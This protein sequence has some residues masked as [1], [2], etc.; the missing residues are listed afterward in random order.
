MPD[1]NANSPQNANEVNVELDEETAEG[2]YSNLVMISHSSEEF[3]LDFI[4]VV[5]GVK[6]ARVKSRII[7]TPQHAARL[8]D[9]LN[10]NIDRYEQE[11]GIIQRNDGGPSDPMMQFGGFGGEA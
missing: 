6:K 1:L 9:A 4:R 5:P 11:H 8:L 10:E 2:T 3:V 7:I